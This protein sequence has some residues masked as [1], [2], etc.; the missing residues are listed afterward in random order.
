MKDQEIADKKGYVRGLE[1]VAAGETTISYVDGVNGIL[2]YSGYNIHELAGRTSFEEVAY[3]LWHDHEDLPNERDLERFSHE[4]IKNMHIPYE[5]VQ[6][7]KSMPDYS[8]PMA[9]LRTAVSALGCLDPS[10]EELSG[11]GFDKKA[12]TLIARVMSIVAGMHRIK[13][14]EPMLE[15]DID[16]SFAENFLYMF[17]GTWPDEEEA[18][19]F[20]TLLV[21]H[22]DHGF[23]ASTFSARVTISTLSDIYSG[24]TSAIGTLKGPL[25]GGANQKVM[26]MLS[27]IGNVDDVEEYIDSLL[28]EKKKIMGFGHRI[29]KTEDPR[30]RHLKIWAEKL[31][32][33]RGQEKL[34]QIATRIEKLVMEKKGIHPNVDFYSAVVQYALDIPKEYYTTIFAAS[35]TPGWIAHIREQLTDNR[36]IRPTSRY[37]GKLDKK[38]T[39]IGE[40][41]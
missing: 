31:A 40:R 33:K 2:V 21:L 20:D 37:E 24:L 18:K 19:A 6:L 7:I 5:V 36:L 22:A 28:N 25:H 38:W 16:R 14:G 9:V 34:F 15:P 29:Y 4:L 13:R 1:G 26:E 12:I 35:R 30:A 17:R 39:A 11:R 41:K 10:A 3:L 32:A 27:D 23:N 8:H